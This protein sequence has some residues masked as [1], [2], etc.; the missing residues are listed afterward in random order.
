MA[1]VPPIDVR[2]VMSKIAI[3]HSLRGGEFGFGIFNQNDVRLYAATN[4]RHGLIVFPAVRFSSPGDYHYTV[5]EIFHP[6]NW[7]ADTRIW[8][9]HITVTQGADNRLY[10][11]VDYPESTPVF[12]NMYQCETCGLVEFP[13]LTFNQPGTYEYTLREETPSGDGWTTDG[14]LIRVVVTVVPDG[15]GNLVATIDYPEGFP[16]FVNTYSANPARIIIS[17]CKIA[18]GAPL[19]AGRFEFGLF[20]A[21]GDLIATVRNGPAEETKPNDPDSCNE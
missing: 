11:I 14:R 21:A 16:T 3:A 2:L 1:A 8:P 19:P 4:D 7:E 10:A 13:E 12:K 5:R 9:I 17:A 20:D 15:H 6:P 18:I